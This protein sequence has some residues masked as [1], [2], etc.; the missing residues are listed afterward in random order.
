[1]S[2]SEGGRAG[3]RSAHGESGAPDSLRGVDGL[4]RRFPPVSR[5]AP[6]PDKVCTNRVTFTE[7]PGCVPLGS[8]E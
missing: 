6:S 4:H 2:S 1:M 7:R 5:A 8:L 3:G